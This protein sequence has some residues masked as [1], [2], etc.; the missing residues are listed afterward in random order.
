MMNGKQMTVIRRSSHSCRSGI[1]Q[2]QELESVTWTSTSSSLQQ[3]I[4]AQTIR[5]VLSEVNFNC[6]I[7][8]MVLPSEAEHTVALNR[9]IMEG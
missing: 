5:K 9:S 4:L 3:R 8:L 7:S 6:V 1:H 2:A